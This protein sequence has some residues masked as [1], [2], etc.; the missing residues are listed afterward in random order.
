MHLRFISYCLVVASLV[1]RAHAEPTPLVFAGADAEAAGTGARWKRSGFAA[2]DAEARV[3]ALPLINI[4]VSTASVVTLGGDYANTAAEN[5]LSHRSFGHQ[6]MC[7]FRAT[8]ELT[9]PAFHA[10]RYVSLRARGAGRIEV[11]RANGSVIAS[12]TLNTIATPIP[13]PMAEI[14]LAVGPTTSE[15]VLVVAPDAGKSI[16]LD[17][18][19]TH[20]TGTPQRTPA[21][22]FRDRGSRAVGFADLHVHVSSHQAMGGLRKQVRPLWGVPGGNVTLYGQTPGA[23]WRDIPACN[24]YNH[25][26][27]VA[28]SWE[29]FL[30]A[31]TIGGMSGGIPKEVSAE[32]IWALFL[33]GT[34]GANIKRQAQFRD[35]FHQQHHITAIRRAYDGGLR[36]MGALANQSEFLELMLGGVQQDGDR[37]YV[38]LTDEHDLVRAHVCFVQ[39][40]A[41]L[42][43]DWM[44]VATSADHA[45][46]IIANN[47]LAIVIGLELPDTG[48][49]VPGATPEQE[50]DELYRLGVRQITLIHGADNTLG[51]TQVFQDVYDWFTDLL[52]TGIDA[53]HRVTRTVAQSRTTKFHGIKTREGGCTASPPPMKND[54]GECVLY[55]LSKLDLRPVVTTVATLG[56]DLF[57]VVLVLSTAGAVLS[58]E[59]LAVLP[60][61]TGMIAALPLAVAAILASPVAQTPT[62]LVA[63]PSDL[64]G[65]LLTLGDRTKAAIAGGHGHLNAKGLSARGRLYVRAMMR[66]GMMIDLAHASDYSARA[67]FEESR[68]FAVT[69]YGNRCKADLVADY[70]AVAKLAESGAADCFEASY[71]LVVSHAQFREQSIQ[72]VL[73]LDAQAVTD[74]LAQ[75][76]H[77]VAT[78]VQGFAP[79]EFEMAKHQLAWFRRIGGVVGV[80]LGQEELEIPPLTS[81][82]IQNNCAHSS[83]T[84]AL[85]YEYASSKLGGRGV[86]LASDATYHPMVA[87]RFGSWACNADEASKLEKQLNPRFLQRDKQANAVNYTSTSSSTSV[88]V[89]ADQP[90]LTPFTQDKVVWDFNVDGWGNFGLTPDLLQDAR[91]LGLAREMPTIFRSAQDYVDAWS[92]AETLSGCNNP[93]GK[94]VDSEPV[95]MDCRT[96]C[97]GTCPDEP[98]KSAGAPPPAPPRLCGG[99]GQ[100]ACCVLEGFPCLP[101]L[102]PQGTCTGGNCKC[103][104]G[105]GD[106][107][108]ICKPIQPCGGVGQR[109]CCE[110]EGR[111]CE[112]GLVEQGACAAELGACACK[113]GG[114]SVGVCKPPRTPCGGLGERACCIGEGRTA[115]EPSCRKGVPE[116]GPCTGDCLCTNGHASS[117]GMCRPQTCVQF[118]SEC[119]PEDICVD[120]RCIK[121]SRRCRNNHPEDCGPWKCVNNVCARP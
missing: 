97:N 101:G 106:S 78:T 53:K 27:I 108:S 43:A 12:S 94:C 5:H 49:L 30:G 2:S 111:N 52:S 76:G 113:V 87:P 81:S 3:C 118:S 60:E 19:R 95:L 38:Q 65:R 32:A 82:S 47:K 105:A 22:T 83:A 71:P 88:S 117:S 90:G 96:A 89:R 92:K 77:G 64:A 51:G 72:K 41:R 17:D 99:D 85:A 23:I 46:R 10:E 66:R 93:G 62:G 59:F 110:L 75:P 74:Y 56:A 35:G 48:H 18:I 68:R 120:K 44:E 33:H 57:P 28:S 61:V 11:R 114:L 31:G 58:A 26:P 98:D 8:T 40:L 29:G 36:L 102:V 25:R 73:P 103:S 21:V 14:V 70:R 100:R 16:D 1:S 54:R 15:V 121:G 39:E 116:V 45:Q 7:W 24:G 104:V 69:K 50:V 86:A 9:S 67:V 115:S 80:F 63:P 37:L 6:G 112:P 91:N 84:F 42:N 79:S 119:A 107:L 34:G 13:D 55:L 109:A 4:P 20:T